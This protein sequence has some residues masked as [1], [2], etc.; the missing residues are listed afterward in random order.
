[1]IEVH[2][3]NFYNEII[4]EWSTTSENKTLKAQQTTYQFLTIQHGRQLQSYLLDTS[5]LRASSIFFRSVSDCCPW[6]RTK[7]T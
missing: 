2:F 1:M 7:R 5:A 6:N 3:V 4:N